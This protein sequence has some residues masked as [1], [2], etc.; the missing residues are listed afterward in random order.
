MGA[1]VFDPYP[2]GIWRYSATGLAAVAAVTPVLVAWSVDGSGRNWFATATVSQLVATAFTLTAGAVLYFQFRVHRSSALGWLAMCIAAYGT[3]GLTIALILAARSERDA[4]SGWTLIVELVIAAAVAT[5][6]RFGGLTRCHA[7]PGDPLA[8]GLLV[9]LALALLHLEFEVNQPYVAQ[10]V[11]SLLVVGVVVALWSW[12]AVRIVRAPSGLE[13]W[14]AQRLAVGCVTL[15]TSRA[16]AAQLTGDALS[17]SIVILTGLVGGVLLMSASFAGLRH[18]IQRHESALESLDRRVAL[19]EEAHRD[20]RAR[21]HEVTNALAGI[22]S[23]S[24]LIHQSQRLPTSRR[25]RLEEMLD[26]EAARLTRLLEN[27][28]PDGAADPRSEPEGPVGVVDLDAVLR[29]LTSAQEAVGRR[30][31]WRPSRV[32][33]RGER[34]AV[35]EALSVLLDNARK[36]A[37]GATTTVTTRRTGECVEVVVADDGPGVPEELLDTL[38][39]WEARGPESFGH[40]LGLHLARSRARQ[41]GGS[42]ELAPGPGA[43]FVLRL[44][45]ASLADSAVRPE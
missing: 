43:R 5:V 21:L 2:R 8:I 39:A 37:P 6:V 40:G 3:H 42:L 28:G 18:Q 14:M 4:R 26:E 27:R 23:A 30:V 41:C 11:P 20:Q 16:V 33:V 22:A 15:A 13:P 9:G 10:L 24:E 34:D 7:V 29:P 36:H 35:A 25:R 12:T 44:P 32:L 45:A 1:H 17:G 38:F 31:L 19:M